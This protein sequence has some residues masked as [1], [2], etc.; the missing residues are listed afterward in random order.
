MK[1]MFRGAFLETLDVSNW[2]VSNVTNMRGSTGTLKK[3][4]VFNG[5]P[6]FSGYIYIKLCPPLHGIRDDNTVSERMFNGCRA[7][8]MLNVNNWDVSNVTNMKEMF[9]GAFLE[10]LD[11]SNWDVSL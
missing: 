11:V 10:T 3:A 1:E 2:D 4:R 8:K 5:D 6:P 9:R 7:L